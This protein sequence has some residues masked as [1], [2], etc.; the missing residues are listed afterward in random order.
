MP[1]RPSRA[2][3]C[4]RAKKRSSLCDALPGQY[5]LFAVI[6]SQKREPFRAQLRL[7]STPADLHKRV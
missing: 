7:V 6:R 5:A 3:K 2:V 4:S 1:A